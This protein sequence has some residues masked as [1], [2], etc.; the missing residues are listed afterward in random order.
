MSKAN[1]NIMV[2]LPSKNVSF[3]NLDQAL[4]TYIYSNYVEILLFYIYQPV[5]ILGILGNSLSLYVF[6]KKNLAYPCTTILE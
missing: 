3:Q 2:L 6:M 5:S 1:S 4:E